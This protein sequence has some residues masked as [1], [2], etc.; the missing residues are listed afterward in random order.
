M[1]IGTYT[2][3]AGLLHQLVKIHDIKIED[4]SKSFLEKIM[5][6]SKKVSTKAMNYGIYIY[7]E[8]MLVKNI[9]MKCNF[10]TKTL[11]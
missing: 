7:N 5:G 6:Y 3:W 8:K 4:P 2:D 10:N 11:K 9:Y 1:K